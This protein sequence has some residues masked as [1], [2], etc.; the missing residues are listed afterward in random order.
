MALAFLSNQ[1]VWASGYD[2]E[3]EQRVFGPFEDMK[4]ARYQMGARSGV[5]RVQ[6]WNLKTGSLSEARALIASQQQ[7][8]RLDDSAENTSAMEGK[9]RRFLSAPFGGS[10]QPVRGGGLED[11]EGDGDAL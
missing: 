7:G 4:E 10:R 5:T 3:G 11:D 1:R 9:P 2:K 8:A 6:Y